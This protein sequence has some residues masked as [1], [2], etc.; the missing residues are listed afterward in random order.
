MNPGLD[1]LSQELKQEFVCRKNELNTLRIRT[2][3]E[4]KADR[5]QRSQLHQTCYL[6][7]K[8]G[9]EQIRT[10]VNNLLNGYKTERK[11]LRA[12]L[13]EEGKQQALELNK[14]AKER[15]DSGQAWN[16]TVRYIRRIRRGG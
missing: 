6:E 13:H 12:S 3:L 15:H 10:Q 8:S 4:L 5:E 7:R 14:T 11:N 2:R 9:C 1:G 16:E